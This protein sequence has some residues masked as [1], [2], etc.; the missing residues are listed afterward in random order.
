MYVPL[1]FFRI[2]NSFFSLRTSFYIYIY[3][4]IFEYPFTSLCKSSHSTCLSFFLSFCSSL[5]CVYLPRYS[6]YFTFHYVRL[7]FLS[8]RLSFH[9]VSP[10][11]RSFFPLSTSLTLFLQYVSPVLEG[12][13][14][15]LQSID[16]TLVSRV[17][18][19]RGTGRVWL[20]DWW[21]PSASGSIPTRLLYPSGGGSYCLVPE[22]PL[23]RRMPTGS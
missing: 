13:S 18:T 3:L 7:S 19:G 4:L 21:F 2:C 20:V 23:I 10:L 1:I 11:S 9:S 22:V 17:W 15:A 6:V 14:V 12:L 5:L 8:E 16:R